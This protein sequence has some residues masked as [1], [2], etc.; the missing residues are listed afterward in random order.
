MWAEDQLY[1]METTTST[2]GVRLCHKESC[3]VELIHTKSAS[4]SPGIR[5]EL[6]YPA[7]QVINSDGT[8]LDKFFD[9][10]NVK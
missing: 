7:L 9:L 5:F 1:L 3:V 10:L 6:F 2:L 8:Q 4:S